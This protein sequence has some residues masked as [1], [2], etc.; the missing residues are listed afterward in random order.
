MQWLFTSLH[1]ICSVLLLNGLALAKQFR[2]ARR[3]HSLRLD[4]LFLSLLYPLELLPSLLSA[5]RSVR[6][7]TQHGLKPPTQQGS[8]SI[9]SLSKQMARRN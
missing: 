9:A 3:L 5:R 7:R 4:T 8:L 2:A 1:F 6:V